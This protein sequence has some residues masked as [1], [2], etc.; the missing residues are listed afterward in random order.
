MEDRAKLRALID[1]KDHL[2]SW[3]DKTRDRNIKKFS[4]LDTYF[5]KKL[6]PLAQKIFNDPTLKSTYSVYLDYDRPTSQLDMHRDT[7]A[8]TYSI[9]YCLSSVTPWP[10]NIEDN[11]YIIEPGQGLAFM[12]GYDAHGRPPLTDPE[13]NRVEMLMF[14]FCPEDHWYFTEGP[15]Y[16]YTLQEQGKLNDFDTYALSPKL[17]KNQ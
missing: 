7:N 4:E 16:I 3:N 17:N 14:H 10:L 6:E 12:G 8:C 13:N 2:K 9:D 1:S 11:L 5:S 15:D